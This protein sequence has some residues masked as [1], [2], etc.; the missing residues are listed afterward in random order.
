MKN[1][2]TT[3]IES[4]GIKEEKTMKITRLM[5][6]ALVTMATLL[7]SCSGG[8]GAKPGIKGDVLLYARER[9]ASTHKGMRLLGEGNA[10]ENYS[11]VKTEEGRYDCITDVKALIV[12]VDFTDFPADSLPKGA[13]GTLTDIEHAVLGTA[14]Q[15]G[16]ESLKSYYYKSSFGQCNITGTVIQDWYHTGVTVRQFADGKITSS[17]TSTNATKVLTKM[18]TEWAIEEKGINPKDYDANKDG[19]ID[20]VIMIYSCEPHVRVGGKEV[21]DELFWAFC[22]IRSVESSDA[23]KDRPEP[24]R[25]FWSSYYTF[26]ED[27]Y[28]DADGTH[29]DWTNKQI[30]D[31]TATLDAHTL[32]HEFGHVLS[33]PDYYNQ[34]SGEGCYEPLGALDMMAYNIGDHNAFSKALYGWTAPY[35]VYGNATVTMRSTTD[36]GEFIVIPFETLE[37]PEADFTLLSQYVMIEFLTPT[38]VAYADGKDAYAGAYPVYYSVPGVRVTLVDARLGMFDYSR[39]FLGFTGSVSAPKNGYTSFACDNVH[40]AYSYSK[41]CKL[42]EILSADGTEAK[43]L[44]G[45]KADNNALYQKG[46]KFNMG[47]KGV[48]NDFC[49]HDNG[50]AWTK[51]FNFGFTITNIGTD[52]C[53]V[54]ISKR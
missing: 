25:Y 28:W 14:E 39:K 29:K 18:V 2:K 35:V 24:F 11:S 32:I 52:T 13:T 5:S 44:K 7:S 34:E 40:V 12:A 26:Y 6:L 54:K 19:F 8:A 9:Y 50:G 53:T 20:S 43:Y 23:N 30:K 31:G 42:I 21:D 37:D 38:G 4:L 49:G 17:A 3:R 47:V 27:G 45:G 10:A 16:W 51:K 22:W 36:T 1:H 48:W 15:T 46:D 33:L 41:H